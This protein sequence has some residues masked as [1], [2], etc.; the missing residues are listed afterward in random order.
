MI[1]SCPLPEST[2]ALVFEDD[3]VKLSRCAIGIRHLFKAPAILQCE[4]MSM[5]SVLASPV[6]DGE[7]GLAWRVYYLLKLPEVLKSFYRSSDRRVAKTKNASSKSERFVVYSRLMEVLS[8]VELPDMIFSGGK[9][10]VIR[11]LAIKKMTIKA[12]SRRPQICNVHLSTASQ[13][14]GFWKRFRVRMGQE[15]FFPVVV[16]EQDK[17]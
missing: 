10:T 1:R 4:T 8:L 5:K 16:G 11:R 3:S 13:I 17:L 7:G 2:P 9:G 15:R 14:R 6:N 12:H